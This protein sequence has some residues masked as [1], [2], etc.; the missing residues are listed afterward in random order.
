[1]TRST[2]AQAEMFKGIEPELI[3]Q[4]ERL[5]TQSDRFEVV[6]SNADATVFKLV[7]PSAQSG[8]SP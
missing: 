5:L 6:Y 3:A 2:N 8:R 7:K 1:M 4:F